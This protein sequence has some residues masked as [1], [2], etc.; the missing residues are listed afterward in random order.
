MVGRLASDWQPLQAMHY[1]SLGSSRSAA[2]W[3]VRLC[4]QLIQISHALWLARNQQVLE[5]RQVQESLTVRQDIL[6]QFQLGTQNLL[7]ADQFHVIPGPHGFS[8]DRVLNLSLEDQVLW[9][10][11]VR[12]ARS[13]GQIQLRSPLERMRQTMEDFVIHPTP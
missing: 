7:P 8:L 1:S 3:A 12:N 10:Q 9:L 2:L 6:A 4:R 13:F 5:A 11:A